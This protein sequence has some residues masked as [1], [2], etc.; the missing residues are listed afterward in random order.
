MLPREDRSGRVAQLDWM[1]LSCLAPKKRRKAAF[2]RFCIRSRMPSLENSPTTV[3]SINQF[4]VFHKFVLRKTRAASCFSLG[5]FSGYRF[6][7]MRLMSGFIDASYQAM[8]MIDVA[9]V[10]PQKFSVEFLEIV[11]VTVGFEGPIG[12]VAGDDF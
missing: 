11:K 10:N 6:L 4:W 12:Q 1:T 5:T 9:S 2:C 7:L 8:N 3:L